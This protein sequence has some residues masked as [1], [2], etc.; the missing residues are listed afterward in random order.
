MM[1]Y[2]WLD[3]CERLDVLSSNVCHSRELNVVLWLWWL[4]SDLREC[5]QLGPLSWS[6][7]ED[8]QLL[9]LAMPRPRVYDFRGVV[10]LQDS[11]QFY[12][13]DGWDASSYST[14]TSW[15][16]RRRRNPIFW[17]EQNSESL[18]V[19]FWIV[20]ERSTRARVAFTS[21]LVRSNQIARWYS[22]CHL[23]RLSPRCT[24]RS[25]SGQARRELSSDLISARSPVWVLEQKQPSYL[26]KQPVMHHYLGGPPNWP[27]AQSCLVLRTLWE[28][29]R[30]VSSLTPVFRPVRDLYL[31]AYLCGLPD[32]VKRCHSRATSWLIGSRMSPW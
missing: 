23:S 1:I 20:A 26:C 22:V 19:E 27:F 15:R 13:I 9:S 18:K 17:I 3:W 10:V 4:T 2:V 8:A 21:S 28:T 5:N 16:L 12:L 32:T 29:L 25:L 6:L 24:D 7:M 11:A 31:P 30:R 14:E